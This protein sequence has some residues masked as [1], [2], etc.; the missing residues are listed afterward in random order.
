M[1][2]TI[3]GYMKT[4][5]LGRVLHVLE[6]KKESVNPKTKVRRISGKICN[7]SLF[8]FI[9]P[10]SEYTISLKGSINKY[11]HGNNFIPCNRLEIKKAI[12]KL[13]NLTQLPFHN[14]ILTR[15]DFGASL[16]MKSPVKL[17]LVNLDELPF[18]YKKLNYANES[19]YF[20]NDKRSLIFYDKIKQCKDHKE[21]IP[22]EFF[23][24][25]VLRYELRY[26]KRLAQ[27]FGMKKVYALDL[28]NK[29]FY[30]ELLARWKRMY[31]KVKKN[32]I[33]MPVNIQGL[34]T[35]LEYLI[36]LGIMKLGGSYK[37]MS[38]VDTLFSKEKKDATKKSRIRMRI[39]KISS[40]RNISKSANEIRELNNKIK[41][42]KSTISSL[43]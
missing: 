34:A 8:I 20:S 31:S 41:G 7:L 24:K 29:T 32:R 38:I 22:S 9:K 4:S 3:G 30:N 6:N 36:S 2:D 17:Y 13:S 25:N 12:K 39:R 26:T 33:I 16:A 40:Q 27:Q 5:I 42:Y 10:D 35:F 11:I 15:I 37:A 21:E 14:L 18:R 23:G 43:P 19:I 28:Y 1:V